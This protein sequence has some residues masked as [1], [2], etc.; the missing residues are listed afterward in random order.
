V[1]FKFI[2]PEAS[3][4]AAV[5]A[6]GAGALI[7][8]ALVTAAYWKGVKGEQGLPSIPGDALVAGLAS[9]TLWNAGNVCS[10]IAQSPPLS[11]PY[12]IAYPILQ[13]AL[14]FGGLLGIFVFKEIEG[15]AVAVFWAGAAVLV[16]GVVTLSI[17]GPGA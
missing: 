12:G 13:C 6:F 2:P 8:G 7:A 4:L 3:G 14:F 10:I 17:N 5:P 15:R 1:P 11:L 9:G 16:A